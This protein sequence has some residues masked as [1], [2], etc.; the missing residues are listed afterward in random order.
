MSVKARANETD[1]PRHW[2]ATPDAV[3]KYARTLPRLIRQEQDELVQRWVQN[4]DE[5]AITR[6]FFD[7]IRVILWAVKSFNDKFHCDDKSDWNTDDL[8]GIGYQSFLKAVESYAKQDLAS[9]DEK[10]APSEGASQNKVNLSTYIYSTVYWSIVR[11]VSRTLPSIPFKSQHTLSLYKKK[12]DE[13]MKKC[14]F[15][16]KERDR[17]LEESG[18]PIDTIYGTNPSRKLVKISFDERRERHYPFYDE[19]SFSQF[20]ALS[21]EE[22]YESDLSMDRPYDPALEKVEDQIDRTVLRGKFH[23]VSCSVLRS[24]ERLVLELRNGLTVSEPMSF[25]KIAQELGVSAEYVRQI[26]AQALQKLRRAIAQC[27]TAVY[28]ETMQTDRYRAC[29]FLLDYEL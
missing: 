11:D 19:G 15:T 20:Y 5:K 25:Q 3:A 23:L 16:P 4:K 26:E 27:G 6:L 9:S 24:R 7:K 12:V 22:K 17:L 2:G 10:L 29:K 14:T 18:V 28:P 21:L 8:I 13:S 1:A